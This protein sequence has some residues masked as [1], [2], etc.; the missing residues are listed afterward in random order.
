[1]KKR[2]DTNLFSGIVNRELRVN[3]LYTWDDSSKYKPMTEQQMADTNGMGNIQTVK[4]YPGIMITVSEGYG[5]PFMTIIS[6]MYYPFISLLDKT[7][8]AISKNL[9]EIFPDIG[10]VEFEVDSRTLDIWKTEK[11]LKSGDMTMFPV[12]W[13]DASQQCFPAIK[14]TSLRSPDGVII[15]LEDAMAISK[16]LSCF[17]PNTY[18]VMMLHA[19][20]KL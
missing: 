16:L 13:V 18:G 14:C 12:V 20:G 5:K 1:M 6:N 7:I 4:I 8:N 3:Y 2:I 11:A 15:P 9:Y 19:L 10:K 17:D